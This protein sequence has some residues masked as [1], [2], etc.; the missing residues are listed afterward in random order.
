MNRLSPLLL[1]ALLSGL[2]TGCRQEEIAIDAQFPN[3]S[4]FVWSRSARAEVFE[5]TDQRTACGDALRA[6]NTG[7]HDE[8]VQDSGAV[9]VCALYEGDVVFTE[10]PGRQLTVVVTTYDLDNSVLAQGCSSF[11]PAALAPV[12]VIMRPSDQYS[13]TYSGVTAPCNTAARR[14][15]PGSCGDL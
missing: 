2:V 11:D 14:C 12:Q 15:T 6:V 1:L 10:L 4:V 5:V 13:D 8:A 7:A 3:T 9:D